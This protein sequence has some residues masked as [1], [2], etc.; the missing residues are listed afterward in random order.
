MKLLLSL[1]FV[2]LVGCVAANAQCSNTMYGNY[3]C[4]S[5]AN[6]FATTT[7]Q[8]VNFSVTSGNAVLGYLIS[9]TTS[10]TLG[11]SGSADCANTVN[12]TAS[13]VVI[14]GSAAIV[15]W[16]KAS[17]SGTCTLTF[18][19]NTSSTIIWNI[20]Q[21]SGWNGTYDTVGALALIGFVSGGSNVNC[22]SVTTT[23]NGDLVVG[24]GLAGSEGSGT[25]TGVSP[26][27]TVQSAIHG[28][29][30][31]EDSQATAGSI[32][33]A[34]TYSTFDTMGCATLSLELGQQTAATPTFSL[35]SGTY[36]SSLP[37]STTVATST[38]TA[39]LCVTT[40]NTSGCTPATPAAISPGTC[41]TGTQY[42]ADSQVLTLAVGYSN[43]SCLAT[44]SGY[45]NSAVATSGQYLIQ[46][47]SS[48]FN[49]LTV[50]P[51]FG[52][53]FKLNG[54]YLNPSNGY[55]AT[56]NSLT[57]PITA[58]TAAA[59]TDFHTGTPP[60]TPTSANLG[61]STYSSGTSVSWAITEASTGLTYGNALAAGALPRPINIGGTIYDGSGTNNLLCTTSSSAVAATYCGFDIATFTNSGGSSS[62]GFWVQPNCP[63][64][65][66]IDCGADGGIAGGGGNDYA[67]IHFSNIAGGDSCTGILLENRG[68]NSSTCPAS[69]TSGGI[70]RV[71]I[72]LNAGE[73]AFTGTFTSSSSSISATQT[74][75]ANQLVQLSTS[76]TA[77][78]GF[79]AN[80]FY[81]V[82]ATGLSGSALQLSARQGG[83]PI[84]ASSAGTGTQTLTVY[85]QMTVCSA[86]GSLLTNL[87]APSYTTPETPNTVWAGVT[88]E[89]P[90]AN[91]YSFL[92]G[93]YVVDITG[94]ISTTECF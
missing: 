38:T 51:A 45:N 3:T 40:C 67:V 64:N 70:Y 5:T 20:W 36:S 78:G 18:T 31:I 92:F 12:T 8:A 83:P 54:A 16:T 49:G 13:T 10:V 24:L 26:F 77:P 37:R 91:G 80:A 63:Y 65:F 59:F 53:L 81:Y 88:G 86:T 2:A 34:W 89:G 90:Q 6:S 94:K 30:M 28:I 14:G 85:N 19:S 21:W 56:V 66:A 39:Y 1:A 29:S 9:Q 84:V 7:S 46:P 47:T 25:V 87:V 52:N 42:S 23:V 93:G 15:F 22:P 33:P 79:A 48:T 58:L 71:N 76:G 73:A 69:W 62:V 50:G 68:G 32:T 60:N 35:S 4:V 17:G 41:S 82:L 75:A 72:Q 55:I 57:T 27:T 43:Y 11:V 61:T 44:E 74:A